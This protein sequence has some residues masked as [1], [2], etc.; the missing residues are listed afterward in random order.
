[1]TFTQQEKNA[2]TR[3]DMKRKRVTR[4]GGAGELLRARDEAADAAPDES[5]W[6]NQ[7]KFDPIDAA[8]RTGRMVACAL[9]RVPPDLSAAHGAIHR[10]VEALESSAA[11]K[12]TSKS[13]VAEVFHDDVRL[14][15][16]LEHAGYLTLEQ[17]RDAAM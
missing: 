11:P 4:R 17:L 10:Y 7:D 16:T 1:M 14:A 9:S 15:N 2:N 13:H 6:R 3:A 5:P 8:H 12:L